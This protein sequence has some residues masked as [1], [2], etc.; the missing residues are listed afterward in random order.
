M[1]LIPQAK[2]ISSHTGIAKVVRVITSEDAGRIRF[3]GTDWPAQFHCPDSQMSALPNTK[4][5]VIGR[6]GLT[7]LVEPL[8]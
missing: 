8:L 3:Q 6:R 7:L 1:F 2:E 4:V 5:K